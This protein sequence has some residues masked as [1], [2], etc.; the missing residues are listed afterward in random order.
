M[1]ANSDFNIT[2]AQAKDILA[3]EVNTYHDP[4]NSYLKAKTFPKVND[5]KAFYV[6]GDAIRAD[7][8]GRTM[9]E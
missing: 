1:N 4:D 8:I 7:L 2:L 3:S 9:S 5:F 6:Y